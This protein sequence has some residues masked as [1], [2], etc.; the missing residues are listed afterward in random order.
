MSFPDLEA[1]TAGRRRLPRC[2]RLVAWREQV[3]ATSAPPT[4]TRLLGPAGPVL[5][6]PEARVVIVG[7]APAA[8]GANRTGRM[9]TGDRSGDW[10]F[11]SLHR[12]GFANQPTRSPA[13]TGSTDRRVGHRAGASAPRRQPADHRRTRPVRPYL[14]AELDLLPWRVV[15]ALGGS[16]GT[17]CCAITGWE[18][19]QAALR[20]RAEV[21]LPTA[22]RCS[23]AT[24][25]ASRTPSPAGSPNRCS[26]RCSSALARSRIRIR[27][28]HRS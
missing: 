16:R 28:A 11:A 21:P 15:V 22:A 8:H 14:A 1:V 9:F 10:L 19:T 4:P 3:A 12:T 24:T 6:R 7:L 18:G 27:P 23:A 2:P 25:S 17:R 20:S 13:T 26:T 5:R